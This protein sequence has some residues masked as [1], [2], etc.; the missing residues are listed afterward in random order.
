MKTSRKNARDRLKQS[1]RTEYERLI[2]AAKLTPR[3][4]QII[5]LHILKNYSVCKVALSLSYCESLVRKELSRTYDKVAF[6]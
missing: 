1:T 2:H 3:Q 4:N 5:D 6:L